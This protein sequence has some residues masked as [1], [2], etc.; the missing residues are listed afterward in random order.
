V[1]NRCFEESWH[2]RNWIPPNSANSLQM[3]AFVG[4]GLCREGIIV[5]HSQNIFYR[6]EWTTVVMGTE[7]T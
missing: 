7:V 5:V 3:G 4:S 2:E 1:G 6:I